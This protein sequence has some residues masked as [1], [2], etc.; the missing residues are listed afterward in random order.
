MSDADRFGRAERALERIHAADPAGAALGYHQR[1][2]S[3]VERLDPAASEPLRLAARCQHL[4]RYAFPRRD[5]PAGVLGYKRWRA[6]LARRHADEARTLLASCGY[7]QETLDRVA[8][9]LTKRN[10]KTD[11]EV[12][13]L[14]DAIC[15]TF[16]ELELEPFASKHPREKLIEILQK[17][18]QK[19]SPRGRDAALALTLPENL[20]ELVAA[21]LG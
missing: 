9:L 14:E 20:R 7:E 1:L 10:L 17:T 8:S 5:Y 19:M 12:Q 21:A 11:A 2:A 4:R 13:L 6:D 16:L 15:L 18:W 3:W